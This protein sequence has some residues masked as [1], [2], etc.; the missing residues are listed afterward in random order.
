MF[1]EYRDLLSV[2]E[3]CE[4]LSIG[5]NSAYQLLASGKIHCFRHNRIWK[6]P[7]AGVVEYVLKQS[8]LKL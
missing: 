5:K 6:I 8:S 4:M 7:K 2:E 1:E 3:M